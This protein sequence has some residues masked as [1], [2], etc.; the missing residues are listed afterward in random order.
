MVLPGRIICTTDKPDGANLSD[1]PSVSEHRF[2]VQV[3]QAVIPTKILARHPFGGFAAKA[4]AGAIDLK[5]SSLTWT[6][7]G[8][9][10]EAVESLKRAP[11][12]LRDWI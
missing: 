6:S 9:R 7:L 8:L 2:Q 3:V 4:G 12:G 11:R 1:S 10:L 5:S